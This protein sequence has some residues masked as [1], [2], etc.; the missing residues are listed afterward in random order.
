MSLKRRITLTICSIIILLIILISYI[1]YIKSASIINRDA[2]A[3]MESQLDRAR[4]NIDLLIEITQLETEKLALDLKVKSFLEHKTSTS[5]LNRY[6]VKVMKD[7]NAMSNHYM[8]LFILN[9]DGYI[10]ATTMPEA[11]DLDLSTRQYFQES[12]KSN[13]TVT[14]DI[15]IARSDGSLIVITVSPIFDV[16]NHVLAYAGTAIY[17]EFLSDFI[18]SF[19]LGTTGYYVIID[20]NNLVLSHPNKNLIATKTT[21]DIPDEFRHQKQ[22][23]ASNTIDR[24]KVINSNGL[25]ELQ[26]YK[27]IE[28]NNWALIAIL[29]ESEV[30][31][32][33]WGLLV[34]VIVIGIFAT[35]LAVFV[36]TYISN[37]ISA[38]ITAITQYI[39]HAAQGSLLISK[40]ISDSINELKDLQDPIMQDHDDHSIESNDE[41]GN[42]KKSLKNLKKYLASIGHQFNDESQQLIKNSQELSYT[43][44][45]TSSR[46]AK[47][48]SLLS[49]DL[50]TSITLIKGYAKGILSGIVEDEELKKKFMDEI[51]RSAEDIERITCDILDS[52]YEA[53]HTPKL[54]REKIDSKRLTAK[55]FE[56][57]KQ[58]IL[59]SQR[60]FVG[61]YECGKGKLDIDPIKISRVWNN[62]LS[63]ATK[64]SDEGSTIQIHI[65]Q[66]DRTIT[67]KI[68][69][70]GIGI[71]P[72]DIDRVFD[73]FYT[74]HHNNKQGYGLG[75]F[76]AKSF[77]E[78]H[79][80]KLHFDS[81]YQKGSSFWFDLNICE[82]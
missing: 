49:H 81:Q 36:G 29:P 35:L 53:Q 31:E 20:S 40:S 43:I 46:T 78:A 61:R 32:K 24:K 80:S 77:V 26:M 70:E 51:Y 28:S 59:G 11:M 15:L 22:I 42:L 17:A 14:S 23:N 9:K 44:E 82:N 68:I 79:D 37:K 63:N 34:Y 19:K 38:P 74:G 30:Q 5:S 65:I 39:D 25:K 69:D 71:A 12:K 60:E 50:K 48:I 3:Y 10:V 45:A 67:F 41:I 75:L 21:Y 73:M 62:L 1:I 16:S 54:H 66:K 52:A 27:L 7:K 76:I 57:A 6:L 8:D 72:D 13:K 18:N 2:E 33:S 55:L 47:F 4:E 58:Y 64:F 56:T